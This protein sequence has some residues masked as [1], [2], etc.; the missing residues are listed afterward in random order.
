MEIEPI[1]I[2]LSK[3]KL[4]EVLPETMN[5]I[6]LDNDNLGAYLSFIE[7]KK[8]IKGYS[9]FQFIPAQMG[10]PLTFIFKRD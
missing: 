5:W 3:D 9:L 7:M 10:M 4:S 1:F 6:C 2:V 8:P